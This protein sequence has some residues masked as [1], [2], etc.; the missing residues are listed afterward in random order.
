MQQTV[1]RQ[2]LCRQCYSH[3]HP[4][5]SLVRTLIF[6]FFHCSTILPLL[7]HCPVLCPPEAQCCPTSGYLGPHC[8]GNFLFPLFLI[9]HSSFGNSLYCPTFSIPSSISYF[10]RNLCNLP[11]I[12]DIASI[13]VTKKLAATIPLLTDYISAKHLH[14]CFHTASNAWKGLSFRLPTQPHHCSSVSS[15]PVSQIK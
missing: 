9:T 10:Y 1:F 14:A 6:F 13:L 12:P 5:K 15:K 4:N 7:L 2:S 3:S 11:P 8:K